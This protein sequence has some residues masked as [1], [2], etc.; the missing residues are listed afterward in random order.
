MSRVAATTLKFKIDSNFWIL[1]VFAFYFIYYKKQY[2][3]SQYYKMD[4]L[5]NK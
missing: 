4:H 2:S 3:K 1:E 5:S